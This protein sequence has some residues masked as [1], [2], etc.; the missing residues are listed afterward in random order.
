ML[1][2]GREGPTPLFPSLC[3]KITYIGR[4][5]ALKGIVLVFG[6]M[7][8]GGEGISPLLAALPEASGRRREGPGVG[9][10]SFLSLE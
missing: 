1:V 8:L 6:L 5:D 9:L 7:L 10:W 2:L 4:G 3:R